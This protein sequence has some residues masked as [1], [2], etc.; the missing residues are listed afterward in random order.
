MIKSV[1]Q[2]GLDY[3]WVKLLQEAKSLGMT[4]EEVREFLSG[5]QLTEN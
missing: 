2:S 5:G 1:K 4:T 3:E